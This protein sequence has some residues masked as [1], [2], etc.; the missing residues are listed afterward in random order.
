MRYT[1]LG[2][3]GISISRICLGCM[4]FG[5]ARAGQHSWT[6]DYDASRRVID[7]ALDF[8]VTFFDTA[9]SYQNGTSESYLGRALAASARREEVVVATKFVLADPSDS[10]DAAR[11]PS[12][13]TVDDRIGRLLDSSLS[14]LGLDY[15]DLYIYH[16]W[17]WSTPVEE[18]LAALDRQVRAGKVRALG[19]SNCYAWQ[20]AEAN[21]IA[22]ANGWS[23]FVSY[24]GHMNAI[25]RE[26][27]REM[28][29]LARLRDIS[30]TPYSALAGG[31]LARHP[32]TTSRR[33]IEDGYARG[34]YELTEDIDAPI[35]AAVE[36]IAAARGTTMT[37]I[38]LAWLLSKVTAPVVGATR[39][40]QIDG[41]AE[42]TEI[43]L[44]AEE[45]AEIEKPYVP[46]PIVGV[47]AQNRPPQAA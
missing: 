35:I 28:V 17:D 36:R 42:A 43:E 32:G 27:E 9:M 34:K 29:P 20:L 31:R 41:A 14:R 30:L 38:A 24:Q 12:G 1:K 45:I 37:A 39:A 40:D 3:T 46:H 47:M 10:A 44:T 22:R 18:L 23:R 4:G 19:I 16:M 15:L 8:G 25:A 26:D 11:R 7:R 2:D 21:A 5:D 13:D 6:L 33:L